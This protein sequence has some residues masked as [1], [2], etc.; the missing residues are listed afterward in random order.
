MRYLSLMPVVAG[1]ALATPAS[2]GVFICTGSNCTTTDENVLVDDRSSPV[3]GMTNTS[4]VQVNYTSSTDTLVAAS[5]GQATV[6]ALD[7]L[8]NSVEFS[9]ASGF[10][11]TSAIF[12]LSPVPGNAANE[13][14][15]IFVNYVLADGTTGTSTQSVSKNGNNFFGVYGTDGTMFTSIGFIGNPSTTGISDIR[16]LRLGGV[17]AISSAVPEPSTWALLLIGFAAVGGVMRTRR[18]QFAKTVHA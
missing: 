13:A 12:N 1:L 14:T 5:A 10:A 15:S 2:A 4:N 8:L 11:F 6:S 3:T 9:L 16:Q 18:R 17:T 7:G